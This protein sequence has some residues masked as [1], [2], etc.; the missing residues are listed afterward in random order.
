MKIK[1]QSGKEYFRVAFLCVT[2]GAIKCDVQYPHTLNPHE[3]AYRL[4]G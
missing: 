1:K 2:C 4:D 3:S